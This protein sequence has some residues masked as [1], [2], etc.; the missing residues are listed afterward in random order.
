MTMTRVTKTIGTSV[1]A[2]ALALGATMGAV[3]AQGMGNMPM[4][5]S[6]PDAPAQGMAP[7][8]GMAPA[9]GMAPMQGGGMMGMMMPM[10]MSMMGGM[11]MANM[12]MA[13]MGAA[14]AAAPMAPANDDLEQ[15]V[16]ELSRVIATLVERL[17]Q[18]EA[19]MGTTTTPAPVQ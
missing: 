6:A 19:G 18:M 11:P 13:G 1:L 4:P 15:K 2:A 3:T 7:M 14:P 9:Q 5:E 10:M 16:D 12:P 8:Q 17:D